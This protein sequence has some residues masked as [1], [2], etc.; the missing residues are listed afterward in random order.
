MV[1]AIS[2]ASR[3]LSLKW[4]RLPVW[5]RNIST[6]SSSRHGQR[7]PPEIFM[8][9]P[10]FIP[11]FSLFPIWF[12]FEFYGKNHLLLAMLFLQSLPPSR[13]FGWLKTCSDHSFF[14]SSQFCCMPG[15]IRI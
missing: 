1:L 13:L 4:L 2:K 8:R 9:P 7:A 5:A 11:G 15:L 12:V 14:G 3:T 10:P 6:P